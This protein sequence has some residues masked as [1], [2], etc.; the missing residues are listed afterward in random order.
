[1]V[2]ELGIFG[3]KNK[4]KHQRSVKLKGKMGSPLRTKRNIRNTGSMKKR[5]TQPIIIIKESDE[6]LKND[7]EDEPYHEV[8]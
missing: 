3:K 1:M 4:M 5:P 8:S 7:S 2:E 6:D